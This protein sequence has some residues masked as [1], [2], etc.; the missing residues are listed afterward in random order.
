MGL[1]Q[2]H[3]RHRGGDGTSRLSGRPVVVH[4]LAHALAALAAADAAGHPVEIWSA[5]GA[6]AYLGPLYWQSLEEKARIRYPGPEARFVLDCAE[7]PGDVLAAIRQGLQWLCFTGG[8]EIRPKLEDIA[9]QAGA[10]LFAARPE[11]LDLKD[12][13]DVAEAC[14]LWFSPQVENSSPRG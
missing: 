2:P 12:V 14:R 3:A 11:A 1:L 4:S 7:R 10:T 8:A 13:T 9:V 5:V 6:A